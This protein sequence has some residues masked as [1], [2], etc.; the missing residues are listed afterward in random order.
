VLSV[1]AG[2]KSVYPS[3]TLTGVSKGIGKTQQRILD[4]LEAASDT[5]ESDA[6]TDD[7]SAPTDEESGLK[8]MAAARAAA[9]NWLSVADLAQRIG[10]SD[11]QIRRAVRSLESRRLV[12]ITR[13][14]LGQKGVGEYGPLVQRE[15]WHGQDVP[16]A[17]VVRKGETWPRAREWGSDVD[18]DTWTA[19]HDIEFVHVGMPT[20]GLAVWSIENRVEHLIMKWPVVMAFGDEE[21]A[22]E[23]AGELDRIAPL[24]SPDNE[25]GPPHVT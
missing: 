4:E 16:T 9:H 21:G 20:H 18:V 22:R 7:E 2:S 23:I 8:F 6:A 24:S 14:Q 3:G 17:M 19:K 25:T 10:C 13:Q 11:R 1:P 5:S 12:V 15:S